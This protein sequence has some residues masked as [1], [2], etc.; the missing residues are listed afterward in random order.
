MKHGISGRQAGGVGTCLTKSISGWIG[1]SVALAHLHI[2]N[3]LA[4]LR[5]K[6]NETCDMIHFHTAQDVPFAVKG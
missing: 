1:A 2:H 3:Q 4:P 6:I 5:R